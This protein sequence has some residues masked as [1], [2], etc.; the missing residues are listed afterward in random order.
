MHVAKLKGSGQREDEGNELG[1]EG[2]LAD[3]LDV[4]R[5]SRGEATGEGR[6][7]VDV[8]LEQVEEGVVDNGDG[9]VELRL[10]TVVE[11]ERFAGLVAT[12]EGDPLDLVVSVL[13]VLARFSTAGVQDQRVL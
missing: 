4:R 1:L 5:G 6:V 7:A 3:D 9:A 13:D 2:L 8:E 10:N 12:R 11:L